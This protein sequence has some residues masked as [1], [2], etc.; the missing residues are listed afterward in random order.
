MFF[1]IPS[2]T[3]PPHTNYFEANCRHYH[4]HFSIYPY[5]IRTLFKNINQINTI[6]TF[7]TL[8]II[9]QSYWMFPTLSSLCFVLLFTVFVLAVAVV[10]LTSQIRPIYCT[11][12][13]CLW[14]FYSVNSS[15]NSF[16]FC[17][18]FIEKSGSINP[19]QRQ[20]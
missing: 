20:V 14:S 2:T 16:I 12:S 11:W 18:L 19:L 10:Q 7:K 8:T 3:D 4:I 13:I 15:S 9:L 17:S 1:S 6:I 5:K